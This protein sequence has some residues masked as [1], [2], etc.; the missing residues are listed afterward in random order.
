MKY[1]TLGF[2]VLALVG[3]KNGPELIDAAKKDGAVLDEAKKNEDA[4][5]N[6][7]ARYNEA[8]NHHDGLIH[9]SVGNR[10]FPEG[11][12]VGGVNDLVQVANPG[13]D[14]IETF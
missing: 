12:N 13:D 6:L 10:E 3:A 1:F 2:A 4:K 14:V 5:A 7:A 11:G 9:G 8:R